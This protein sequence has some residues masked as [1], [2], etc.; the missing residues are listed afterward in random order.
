MPGYTNEDIQNALQDIKNG[1]SQR[2][3]AERNGVPRQTLRDRIAGA[4][5]HSEA[6]K[7]QQKLSEAQE[8]DL[9]DWVLIQHALGFPPTHTQVREFA[10]RIAKNNGYNE[11]IGKHW[12]KNFLARHNK[13][14]TVRHRKIDTARFNGATTNRIKAF[15]QPQGLPEIE[16]IPKENRYNMDEC[17]ILEGQDNIALVVGHA[18]KTIYLQENP[19]S[20]TWTTI[21]E[22]MSADGRVLTPLVIF[23]EKMDQQQLPPEDIDFLSS[24]DFKSST[25]EWT[26]DKIVLTWLKTIFIPHTMP[27]KEGEKRLLIIDGHG[28]HATD[29]FMFECFQN[30]IY[31]LWL[32]P[33]SSHVTQPFNVGVSMPVLNAYRRAVLSQLATDNDFSLKTKII[34]LNCYDHAR[35][36]GITRK[37]IIAGF[38]AS[39]QWPVNIEKP[40]MNPMTVDL[41]DQGQS[42]TP[43]KIASQ[44]SEILDETPQSLKQLRNA[45]STV[46]A[47]E[48]ISQ[49]VRHLFS[50]LGQEMDCQN[51]KLARYERQL[52]QLRHELEE[53]KSNK[54]QKVAIDS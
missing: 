54:R 20:H 4:L 8:R 50:R 34:I 28:C 38:E 12:L 51:A 6:H 29:D 21:V 9:R 18:E 48:K 25:E 17:V 37:N 27:H 19:R 16:A 40:L 2:K 49:P 26:D 46:F 53:V 41:D 5:P 32:P 36:V 3:A 44:P 39:G 7:H 52:T 30:G 22:C 14:K 45:L 13:M 1:F 24:W 42:E 10:H 43:P 31:V 35:K 23:K 11:P 15:F 33:H 47:D